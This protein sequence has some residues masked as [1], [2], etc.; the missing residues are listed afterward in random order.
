MRT[1]ATGDLPSDPFQPQP[2]NELQLNEGSSTSGSNVDRFYALGQ[3]AGLTV[4]ASLANHVE[5]FSAPPGGSLT[6]VDGGVATPTALSATNVS[7]PPT[8]NGDDA[9]ITVS[10]SASDTVVCATVYTC[11]GVDTQ[12][13]VTTPVNL[14]NG[15]GGPDVFG[16]VDPNTPGAWLVAPLRIDLRW[17]ASEIPGKANT[18]NLQVVHDGVVVSTF[19]ATVP[20]QPG[21]A[22]PCRTA[23]VKFADKDLGLTV[24][25]DRNGGWKP[26]I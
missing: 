6:N 13:S 22:L 14:V 5:S 20:P 4:T 2:W 1:P 25:S 12:V 9:R 18:K 19:C 24:Y 11:F 21:Q 7:V 26:G 8:G 10:G 3:P 17:D 15:A 16:V 23:A